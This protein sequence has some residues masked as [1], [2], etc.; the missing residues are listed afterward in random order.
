MTDG[1]GE[2]AYR[3]TIKHS[4]EEEFFRAVARI[5]VAQ[6]CECE[7][8]QCIQQSALESLADLAVRYVKEAGKRASFYAE[9]AGRTECSVFDLIRGLEDLG[10]TQ[11]LAGAFDVRRCVASSGVVRE[12]SQYISL[13]E[14]IPFAHSLPGLPVSRVCKLPP[15]FSVIGEEPPEDHIP[16]WLPAYPDQSTYADMKECQ[17][18]DNR[19][20]EEQDER[21]DDLPSMNLGQ[22]RP[23]IGNDLNELEDALNVRRVD[24]VNPF[25]A[26]PFQY[27]EKEVS[28]VLLPSKLREETI[29]MDGDSLAARKSSLI[30]SDERKKE[31]SGLDK[32]QRVRLTLSSR[33][34]LAMS[35]NLVP[36]KNEV[37]KPALFFE[38]DDEK[39]IEERAAKI[40]VKEPGEIPPE[41]A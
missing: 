39:D 28:P 27:G 4:R 15:S 24:E 10:S 37:Q 2:E 32:R 13:V 1:G 7:G 35:V 11:G 21:K 40:I 22:G 16:P 3:S 25:L 20:K 18:A 30:D 38:S 29:A 14:E 6:I 17:T 19:V 31:I 34:F 36:Q 26:P 5:A 12:I 8:F 33:K 9:L 41:L 23:V